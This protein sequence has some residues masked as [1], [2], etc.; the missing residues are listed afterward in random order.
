MKKTNKNGNA[1]IKFYLILFVAKK[2]T[3]TMMQNAKC[4]MQNVNKYLY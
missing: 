4:K 3:K 2:E 1:K